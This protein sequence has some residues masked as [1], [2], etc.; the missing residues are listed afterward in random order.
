MPQPYRSLD[1]SINLLSNPQH[2]HNEMRLRVMLKDMPPS[3]ARKLLTMTWEEVFEMAAMD[4]DMR[5]SLPMYDRA[6]QHFSTAE[7]FHLK[8]S[9]ML[10]LRD[11]YKHLIPVEEEMA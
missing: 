7:H 4:E 1:N 5:K 9:E 10:H 3:H 6:F 2:R 8:L 11:E